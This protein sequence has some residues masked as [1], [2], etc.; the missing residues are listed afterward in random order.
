VSRA[1]GGRVRAEAFGCRRARAKGILHG[2]CS[3]VQVV[4][5][6]ESQPGCHGLVVM[7]SGAVHHFV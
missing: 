2:G 4:H 5:T 3:G 1:S 7:K 6:S